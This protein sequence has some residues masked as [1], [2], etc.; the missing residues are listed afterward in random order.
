MLL[1][2]GLWEIEACTTAVVS[3]KATQDGRP[4]LWKHR[5][6]WA[7]KNK[8]MQFTDGKYSYIGLVNSGDKTG[9]SIWIGY[10]SAGFAIMNSASYNLNN[11]TIEQSGLE[12]Q[13][14]KKALQTCASVDEFEQ[15]LKDL[16]KPTRLEANFGVID[17][18]GAAADFE[19]ANFHYV[20]FDANDPK[21]APN[22]YLIRSNYSV[23]GKYGKG[24]GYTR[25]RTAEEVFYQA[26]GNNSFDV[27]TIAQGASRNL[28]HSLTKEN[29]WD[30][31]NIP[32]HTPKYV[33][34]KD[35]IPRSGSASSIIIQGVKEKEDASLTTMWSIVGFPLT[36]VCIPLWVDQ[37]TDLPKIVQYDPEPEDSPICHAALNLKKK[38]YSYRLGSHSKY[39][40]DVN[41]LLNANNSGFL[42]VLKPLEDKIYAKSTKM[43][44]TWYKNG[45]KNKSE[46]KEF[47]QWIDQ[48]VSDY[49]SEHFGLKLLKQ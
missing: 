35:F 20:K 1:F 15:F 19:L 5:D 8:I 3:G 6:T 16:P 4:L 31:V 18:L 48:T 49:Y 40:I 13:L 27:M 36:S 26:V 21:Q 34:F 37:K 2:V 9:K 24:G 33:C 32:E 12:G 29:L 10:N 28:T 22:G 38:V 44:S 41:T 43:I 7:T 17:A 23:S 45:K 14:M 11:D 42:Q 30:Y 25:Y 39:Y 47:Y 46:M